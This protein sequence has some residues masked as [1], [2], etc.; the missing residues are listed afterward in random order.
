MSTRVSNPRAAWVALR[1]GRE[2]LAISAGLSR[3][4]TDHPTAGTLRIVTSLTA[5]RQT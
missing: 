5:R 3:R 1:E 2:I 4:D